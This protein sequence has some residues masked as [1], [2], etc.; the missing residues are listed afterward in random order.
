[1]KRRTLLGLAAAFSFLVS[2]VIAAPAALVFGW[3]QP[4][5]GNLQFAGIEGSL[6]R[7]QLA[8]VMI[9][10]RP[11]V[12][13][14]QWRLRFSDLLLARIGADLSSS[15][16]TLLDGHVSRGF[17]ALRAD[18]LRAVGS[19]QTLLLAAGQAFVPLD[20]KAALQLDELKLR[21]NWPSSAQG[22]IR[23]ER[24]SW[25]LSREPL[26]LGSYE[27][28]VAPDGDDLAASVKT[29]SGPLEVGGGGRAKPDR[30]YELHL[31]IK[32]AAG[33]PP[34][35]ASLLQSLGPPDAQGQYHLRRE[36]KLP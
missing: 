13:R 30:S 17:G 27:A 32:P 35:L 5:L 16:A 8:A 31:I 18:H 2:L 15:G 19:L 20:G 4:P 34:M 12:E 1:M 10:G 11:L 23:V 7:G 6:G 14:L 21:D 26:V 28:S 22:S 3:L 25:T 9:N 33:A 36:G 29:L 24:L